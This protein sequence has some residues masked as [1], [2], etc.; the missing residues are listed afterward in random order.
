MGIF[1]PSL[2]KIPPAL[3]IRSNDGPTHE[4]SR[5]ANAAAPLYN[6]SMLDIVIFLDL[7]YV[8]WKENNILFLLEIIFFLFLLRWLVFTTAATGR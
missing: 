5:C 1:F 7:G 8:I 3:K 2:W 6:N 4:K